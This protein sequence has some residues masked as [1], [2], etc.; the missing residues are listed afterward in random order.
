[1]RYRLGLIRLFV[2]LAAVLGP[3]ALQAQGLVIARGYLPDPTDAL[4]LADVRDRVFTPFDG[5]LSLGYR[6]Y[7]TWVRLTVRGVNRGESA[8]SW[9]GDSVALRLEPTYLDEILV[10]DTMTNDEPARAGDRHP[11]VTHDHESLAQRVVLPAS[12]HPR[13]IYLRVRTTSG[14]VLRAEVLTMPAAEAADEA[15]ALRAGFLL[16]ALSLLLAATLVAWAMTRHHLVVLSVAMM[17]SATTASVVSFGYARLLVSGTALWRWADAGY[18]VAAILGLGVSAGIHH[19]IMTNFG[20]RPGVHRGLVGV[21]YATGAL[22]VLVVAGFP[23]PAMQLLGFVSIAAAML[24]AYGALTCGAFADRDS[25][26]RP[27]LQWLSGVY[28]AMFMAFVLWV[29]GLNGLVHAPWATLYAPQ[30]FGLIA[31]VTL[32]A[33]VTTTVQRRAAIT[34]HLAARAV[35]AEGRAEFELKASLDKDAFLAML[36]HE[37]KTP[38]SVIGV[39]LS[40]EHASASL[41]KRARSAVAS[42]TTVLDRSSMAARVEEAQIRQRGPCEIHQEVLRLVADFDDRDRFVTLAEPGVPVVQTD[43]DLLRVVLRNLLENAHKYAPRN[44]LIGVSL[45]PEWRGTRAGVVCEF[46][47]EAGPAGVPDVRL[48]FQRYYRAAG[49]RRQTGSGLGLYLSRAL[50]RRLEGTLD[51]VPDPSMKMVRFRLWIPV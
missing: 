7:P 28:C 14:T 4:T 9:V 21:S 48:I 37:L 47:N 42:I 22:V 43:V 16:G 10:Y 5:V 36:T 38:L 26:S 18:N 35:I 40:G 25:P 29:L 17:L 23:R 15:D 8:S 50:A 44:S 45:R 3:R 30:V 11:P 39:A 51:Y 19:A 31:T 32:M 33:L 20:L 1:M 41:L 34:S 46:G 2:L 49:A 13:D 6:S 12:A 24:L 27:A